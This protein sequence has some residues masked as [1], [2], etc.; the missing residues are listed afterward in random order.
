MVNHIRMWTSSIGT[1]L[2]HVNNTAAVPASA[3]ESASL[4]GGG[5]VQRAEKQVGESSEEGPRP[6]K[7]VVA[8]P[9]RQLMKTCRCRILA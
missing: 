8:R 6:E 4:S 9:R 3:C 1:D 7:A 2:E 5:G